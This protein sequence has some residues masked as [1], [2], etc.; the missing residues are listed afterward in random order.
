MKH[1]LLLIFSVI[2]ISLAAQTSTIQ[3]FSENEEPFSLFINNQQVSSLPNN[4]H[5]VTGMLQNVNYEVV[6]D[7]VMPGAMDIQASLNIMRNSENGVLLFMVPKFF[8]GS[9]IYKGTDDKFDDISGNS[10]VSLN[11]S[12][13]DQGLN[14]SM[15]LDNNANN[16]T[17]TSPENQ[18]NETY[19]VK[20]ASAAEQTNEVYVPGYTGSIGCPKPVSAVRFDSMMESVDNVSFADDKVRVAKRILKTN[21]ITVDQLVAILD[22]VSF[23]ED[24]LDLA[25]FAYD[26]VYDLENYYLVYEVFSFS[27]SIEELENFIDNK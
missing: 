7:Y 9:L 11:M 16:V 22:E 6:I 20:P 15:G 1:Q 18:S 17:I 10:N 27:K 8:Q 13:G 25:K 4:S 23:D 24:Q 21:C 19:L 14:V 12:F 2:S 3:I 5:E 26:Y